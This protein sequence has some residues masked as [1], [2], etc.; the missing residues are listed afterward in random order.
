[1][2]L[3]WLFL[4]CQGP[5]EEVEPVFEAEEIGRC[6]HF[7]ATRKPFFGD[8]HVHTR[9][10]LDA[11]LQGTLVTPVEAYR[12]AKGEAV[13]VQ[14]LTETGDRTRSVQ[15]ERPLDFVVLSDH[16]EFL[17]TVTVCTDPDMPG[18]ESDDCALYRDHP[19]A[20][21]IGLN[22][23]T[24]LE[25]DLARYPYMCDDDGVD[26]DTA[27][28]TAW[29]EVQDAAESAYDRSEA[30][31]F[32]SF[33]GYEWSGGPG[34]YNLHRNVIFRNHVVPETPISYFDEAT[35]EGLWAGLRDR[36]TELGNGCDALTIPH[37]SN[38]SNG[39][40]FSPLTSSGAEYDADYAR[41]RAIMEPLVE[42]FQHKGDSECR[43]GDPS[44]DEACSFEDMPYNSLSGANL[45]L[46]GVPTQRDYVRDALGE[47]LKYQ[48]NLGE[49][50]FRYGMIASTDTHLG[51]PGLVSE[52]NFPG[53]GGAGVPNRDHMNP[54]HVDVL[55]FNPGGLAVLWAEENSREALY[56]A[57]IRKE[58]YGTSGP[59]IVLRFFGG[60]DLP[61][62]MCADPEFAATGYANG[63]PM[64]GEISGT[65]A[66]KFAVFAQR[67][68]M[69]QTLETVQIVKGTLVD[70]E[71]SYEIFDVASGP[72]TELDLGTCDVTGEGADT[73][74]DVWTDPS[75]DASQPAFYYVRV[76]ENETCRWTQHQCVEAGITCDDDT[77]SEWDACCDDTVPT[78]IQERAWSSPIWYT[79]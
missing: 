5:E 10:S 61:D 44:G 64:G 71:P 74:C 28:R 56:Q 21:F 69:G 1:M 62:D 29:K 49:N 43:P 52:A 24:S 57:M 51:A 77:P 53:H 38:V 19:D 8:T 17:S 32:T 36:C 26:C 16:A 31:G 55:H 22:A 60:A 9:L 58:A 73:L 6:E 72:E 67:D 59:R 46:E 54:G 66:P 20:A 42:V 63:V 4:G 76:L 78:T 40:M 50:P 41:D 37:N 45:G 12:F 13:K 15:L 70:G 68:A 2:W 11:N 65:A 34:A 14:P 18:Y 27:Y 75:F 3:M 47:G 30:C 48:A 23:L 33:I 25:G 7:D 39:L 79:P 35:P